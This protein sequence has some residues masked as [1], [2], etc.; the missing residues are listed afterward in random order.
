MTKADRQAALGRLGLGAV[1]ALAGFSFYL[2]VDVLPDLLDQSPRL[3]LFLTALAGSFFTAFLALVGPV[4]VRPALVFAA[5][6]AVAVAALVT[7]PSLRFDTLDEMLRRAPLWA[8]GLV[9][10]LVPLPFAM[11]AAR[12]GNWRDY[13][14]LFQHSWDVVVRYAAAFVFVGLAWGVV[15]LSDT[16]LQ[17]V[18]LDLIERLL[19]VDAMPYLLTGAL[20]GVALAVVNELS[21]YVS[22]FLVLRLLRLLL[23][24]V[25]VVVAVFVAAVPFR[26][27][28]QLFGTVSVAATLMAMAI[29]ATTLVTTAL[30]ADDSRAVQTPMMRVAVQL[31]AVLLPP[32]GAM[33]A[34]AIWIRVD[35]Y[36]LSPDRLA[37]AAVAALVLAYGL[38]YT[39]AVLRRG[40]WAGRIRAANV[41]L[42]LGLMGLAALWLTPVLNPQR[43]ATA[44]QVARFEAG[45]VRVDQLDLWT[46]G[47]DWGRAG[48]EGLERLAALDDHPQAEALAQALARLETS[49]SRFGF[50]RSEDRA[51]LPERR[52]A[53]RA[54]LPVYPEGAEVPAGAFEQAFDGL[55]DWRIE[56]LEQ[57]CA[58]QTPAGRPGCLVLVTDLTDL[59]P[60]AEVVFVAV[61]PSGRLRGWAMFRD[62][63]GWQMRTPFER[64]GTLTL[65]RHSGEVIDALAEGRFTR[66][67]VTI[68]R[69]EV[70]DEVLGFLP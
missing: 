48:V 70:Q 31:M 52:E 59:R 67:P 57:G 19:E 17:L 47:H 61:T 15:A 62:G 28:E 46:L 44:H 35:Q 60:G 21:D 50:E 25:L 54:L 10:I 12:E 49:T 53:L 42:A 64:F 68:W 26:G 58:L 36:G 51:S 69:I 38:S 34:V 43:I 5:A 29:G 14:A 66:R 23:P 39:L 27:L 16:V 9:L 22:A 33:A 11:A 63:E 56:E 4:R 40:D 1:G 65:R 6:Q 41:R 8:A 45:L 37:A 30:D 3:L 18:G 32:L 24:A 13:A 55:A 2:L 7:W 20:L